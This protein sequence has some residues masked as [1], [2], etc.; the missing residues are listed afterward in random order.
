[1]SSV[2][3]SISINSRLYLPNAEV[4]VTMLKFPFENYSKINENNFLEFLETSS[5]ELVFAITEYDVN[6]LN[7]IHPLEYIFSI[8][9]AHKFNEVISNLSLFSRRFN[10]LSYWVPTVVC[11]CESLPLRASLIRKFIKIAIGLKKIRNLNAFLAIMIGIGN[12]SVLRLRNTWSKVPV[13]YKNLFFD[14]EKLL[15]PSRNHR[16][17]RNFEAMVEGTRIPYF[18]LILKDLT[19]KHDGNDSWKDKMLDFDKMSWLSNLIIKVCQ[20]Q[21]SELVSDDSIEEKEVEKARKHVKNL[22]VITDQKN[23]NTR[24]NLLEPR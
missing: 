5:N 18:P 22:I 10:E 11:S 1:M 3:T 6:L 15:D 7:N 4:N 13:K 23:L 12:Q 9:G 24:S 17:Y 14:A 2:G 16:T 8:F 19:F 20:T 21:L